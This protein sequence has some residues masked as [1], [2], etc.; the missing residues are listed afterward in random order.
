MVKDILI[1]KKLKNLEDMVFHKKQILQSPLF[2]Y[3]DNVTEME[4]FINH[5][6]SFIKKDVSLKNIERVLIKNI[7]K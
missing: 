4:Y 1:Y 6:Y 2:F 7:N 3:K 5:E